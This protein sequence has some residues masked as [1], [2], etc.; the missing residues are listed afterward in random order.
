MEIQ[1]KKKTP[2]IQVILA[3]LLV[4]ALALGALVVAPVVVQAQEGTPE[5]PSG[6]PP[7]FEG[8]GKPGFGP[9]GHPGG[10]GGPEFDTYLAEALGIT[11]EEL[12]AARQKAQEAALQAAV[13]DGRLTA[14]QADMI[15]A[16][17]ALMQYI[18]REALTA[19]ALGVTVDD[20]QAAREAGKSIPALIE[21]LGLDADE[22]QAAF[23]AAYE[24][25]VAQAVQDGVIT[26]AQADEFL[27]H[28]KGFEM[29]G[30]G[31]HGRG[32]P[33]PGMNEAPPAAPEGGTDTANGV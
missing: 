27:S 6:A 22:V 11:V 25:A 2:I 16:R 8:M 3:A 23:Q 14:E 13:D 12:Q 32:R 18:D 29:F 9:G 7:A 5:A 1:E 17:E 30:R 19:Q 15:K 26:Q 10:A 31:M 21:E 20:L 28:E 33:G 4:G 24:A